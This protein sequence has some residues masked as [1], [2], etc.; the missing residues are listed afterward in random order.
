M[1]Q[2]PLLLIIWRRPH[3]LRKV[4]DAVRSVAPDRIYVACDGPNPQRVGE[5]AKVAATRALIDSAIDWPCT[6]QKLYS[7]V[8]LGCREGVSRAISWFFTHEEEGIILEDDCVPHPDF[9]RFC[10][11]LLEH[12]RTDTR[13]WSICGSNFQHGQRHGDASYYFSIHGDSWGWATWRRAWKHYD[14]A[15]DQWLSFRDS[16]RLDD[17]FPIPEE[18]I[19]WVEL[20]DRMIV[21][22]E[23]DTWDFQW[24]LTSWMNH[25]LHVW[26]NA[27]LISNIGFDAD[28]SHTFADCPEVVYGNASVSPLSVITHPE[29]ILP[30]RVADHFVFFNRRYVARP[31]TVSAPRGLNAW[32]YRVRAVRNEGLASYIRSRLHRLGQ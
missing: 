28:S 30:S 4:I 20:L 15:A 11:C 1:S 29:Y 8:N 22:S 24:W 9:F 18:R 13:I 17:V 16:G 5:E 12:F 26:P 21:R 7:D 31:P 27:P 2:P 14:A 10:S 6:V 3:A 19:Y 23:I 32:W 25:G